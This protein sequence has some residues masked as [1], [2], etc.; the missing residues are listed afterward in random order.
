MDS[1]ATVSSPPWQPRFK[2]L[3]TAEVTRQRKLYFS[4]NADQ[5]QFF[6]TVDGQTPVVFSG[7]NPPAIV[8]T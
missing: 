2:D 5:T 4:E 6:I 7:D 8:T 1:V 3:A